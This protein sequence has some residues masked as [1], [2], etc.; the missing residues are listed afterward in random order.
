MPHHP[1]FKYQLLK[2]FWLNHAQSQ[3]T[4]HKDQPVGT[5]A[6]FFSGHTW[7]LPLLSFQPCHL[8]TERTAHQVLV[9]SVC[10]SSMVDELREVDL[11]V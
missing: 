6:P 9:Y 10:T 4:V 11:L 2:C 3:G 7:V 5:V 1:F 8:T